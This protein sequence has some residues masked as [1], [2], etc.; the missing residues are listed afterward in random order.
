MTVLQ[1]INTYTAFRMNLNCYG[2]S[3]ELRS[4]DFLAVTDYICSRWDF[5]L[6]Q[7]GIPTR[8]GQSNLIVF[9]E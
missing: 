2:V 8:K 1:L 4:I 6:T 9:Y 5:L 7:A 3:S